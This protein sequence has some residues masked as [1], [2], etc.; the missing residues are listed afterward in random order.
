MSQQVFHL[1]PGATLAQFLID[2][3]NK[4]YYGEPLPFGAG[5]SRRFVVP[6]AYPQG[7]KI[8]GFGFGGRT[9]ARADLLVS[10]IKAGS[11]GDQ[12]SFLQA[13]EGI[14]AEE[15][16][17]KH[18]VLADRLALVMRENGSRS[19]Y[20]G[21]VLDSGIAH[22]LYHRVPER[23][24]SEIVMSEHN[25]AVIRDVAQEQLRAD[26]LKSYGLMPRN[27][28]M[29][30][31]PPGNGKTSLAEALAYELMVPLLIVRYEGLIGSFLGETASRL[32]KIFEHVRQQRCVLFF[33]EFDVIGKER[34]DK[35]ET[36]EI[37]RVVS[38]LLLQIDAL[39]SYAVVVVASN[40]AQLLDSAVWRRFQVRLEMPRPTKKQVV[41][42]IQDYEKHTSLRFG[43]SASTIAD[44]LAFDSFS[45]VEDFCRDV[46]RQAVLSRQA[47][48]ARRITENRI[49]QW[50]EQLKITSKAASRE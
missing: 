40:H 23:R 25:L 11:K 30:I 47:D 42:F 17:N 20:P 39:P 38:S 4:Q 22:L 9:V 1:G 50:R 5:R 6:C 35:H 10:L 2:G 48:D 13:A 33:D 24:L 45:A 36:G 34:G 7:W 32:Q 19:Q 43:L 44:K 12:T 29:I 31:G 21:R 28:L 27:R 41:E 3:N 8:S 49:A 26:L 15:R 46:Y 18:H 37:K 14:I 16:E